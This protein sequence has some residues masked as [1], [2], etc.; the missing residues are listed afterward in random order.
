MVNMKN[1]TKIS[2]A[3]AFFLF[4]A[5]AFSQTAEEK[6]QLKLAKKYRSGI[7]SDAGL[8]K[9][10]QIYSELANKKSPEALVELGNMYLRGEGTEQD[11]T[12]A[13]KYFQ[14][15]VDLGYTPALSRLALMYQ[16][17]A[18]DIRQDFSKAFELYE[19]A[20]KQDDVDGL[21]GA[22]Y[23]T[24]KGF[25]VKQNYAK[26]LAYFRKGADKND[27][28]C[29][30]MLACHELIGYENNQNIANGEKY[31]EKALAHGH[32]WVKDVLQYN[33]V[34]S[35]TQS[36]KRNPNG[37]SD[38]K[39]GRINHIKRNM[40]NNATAGQLNGEWQGKIYTYDWSGKKIDSEENIKLIIEAYDD[41][42][43]LQWFTNDTLRISANAERTGSEWIAPE[44][45]QY[46]LPL[47]SNWYISHS[48]FDIEV[49]SGKEILYAD[50][51]TY[52]IDAREP[53]MPQI[54]VLE[55]VTS[56]E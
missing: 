9:A 23:L 19:L 17:G 51:Q 6:E 14:E 37:W 22:G 52:N 12:T 41:R 53:R 33:M 54:A 47:I 42:L 49:K 55:K 50:L 3:I 20:A 13:Q 26:A 28:R 2:I 30:Y 38:V 36:Y 46:N 31:M 29:E 11:F 7:Y 27:A 43:T 56:N 18:G 1:Y 48:S 15:A 44:G 8:Q 25:G 45:R 39:N 16:K 34:D 5:T 10:K 32:G 24:Y 40:I 35:L 21:Y 4:S